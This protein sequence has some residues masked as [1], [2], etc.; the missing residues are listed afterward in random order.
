MGCGFLDC[1][2]LKICGLRVAKNLQVACGLLD[3][4]GYGLLYS[5]LQVT[6]LVETIICLTAMEFRLR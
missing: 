1:G 5:G 4:S 6:K 2:L 3:F